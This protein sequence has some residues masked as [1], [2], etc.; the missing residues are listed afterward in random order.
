MR[1]A[2]LLAV[3]ALSAAVILPSAGAAPKADQ[4]VLVVLAS[5]GSKPY[6]VAEVQRTFAQAN[7]FLQ[8]ASLGQVRL[9]ADVTPWLTG[10]TSTPGCGASNATVDS[11]FAPARKAA[12]G[13]G[14]D[15]AH[16]D[17][18][19]Y[20]LPDARC[21]FFGATFGHQ[22][23]LTR[24]PTVDLLAHEL[25]HTFGLGHAMGADCIDYLRCS[26]EDTG[27][28]LSPMGSGSLDY[29]AYEKS[30]LGWIAAPAHVTSP[31]SYVLAPP[32]ARTKLPQA[33][34]VDTARGAWWIEYRAKPFRGVVF[35]FVDA[36]NHS[37]PYDQSA[38]LILRPTK[39]ARPYIVK[40][41]TYRIPL[42]WRVTLTKVSAKQ[43]TL[44]FRP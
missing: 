31:K 9:D 6:P 39:K 16:Y 8:R 3:V 10:L 32:T 28:T 14:F 13:A 35:R 18:V 12:A 26:L 43:A 7:Q 36:D 4:R 37:A 21:G 22:V 42:S 27:D 15:A 5:T 33:L 40:G 30:L 23:M 44:R 1:R 2:P 17:T 11:I 38:I 24:Q 20:E 34:V 29:S 41:E 19:I 25:G